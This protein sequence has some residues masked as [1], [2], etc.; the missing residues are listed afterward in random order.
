MLYILWRSNHPDLEYKEG[1]DPIVHLQA[2]LMET[3]RWAEN[4]HAR[5]A[6][7]D[8]NAGTYL[9]QFFN[10]MDDLDK[11]NWSAVEAMDFRNMMIKEGKQAEFLLFDSFPWTL[12][13]RI[14]VHDTARKEN[15]DEAIRNAAHKPLVSVMPEWYY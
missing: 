15:V 8:R 10:R 7:S 14:G 2:D 6:F 11:I 5:W 4:R 13:E 3:I 12:V 9:A 1:Q